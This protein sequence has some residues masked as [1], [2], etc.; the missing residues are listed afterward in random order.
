MARLY[1]SIVHDHDIRLV[2]VA[3]AICLVATVTTFAALE[4]ARRGGRREAAWVALAGFVSAIGIWSTHFVAMLAYSPDIAI[5]YELDATLLSVLAAAFIGGAGWSTF[6][7]NSAGASIAAGALIG[8]AIGT[9]HYV[10][11]AAVNMAGHIHWNWWLVAASLVVGVALSIAAV[12]DYRRRPQF[13]AW[14][15]AAL[16]TSA[17]V[18]LHFTAMAAAGVHSDSTQVAAEAIDNRALA[19]IIAGATLL[20]LVIS[21]VTVFFQRKLVRLQ[22]EEALRAKVMEDAVR[23]GDLQRE[24][25]SCELKEQADISSAAL[26]SMA[27]GLSIY[28]EQDRLVIFNRRY[29][30]L[31]RMPQTLLARGT[32]FADVLAFHIANGSLHRD[33]LEQY[34]ADARGSQRFPGD[35]RI[36]LCDGRIIDVQR[37]PLPHGGWVATHEDVTRQRRAAERSEYLATHD[38]LTG[39]PNRISFAERLDLALAGLG[40]GSIHALLLVDL[41]RFKEVND[42]FGHPVGDELLKQVAVRLREVAGEDVV[43]RLAGD[44]FAVIQRDVLRAHDA[45]ELAGR[46]I[47]TLSRPFDMDGRTITIG[48]S[49]GIA[50]APRDS[51][52][53]ADLLRKGD[54]ALYWVKNV[55]RGGFSF[56]TPRMDKR[57]KERREL[58]NDLRIA[59]QKGQ[60]ELY[61]QPLLNLS[62]RRISGFEALVRWHHPRRGMLQSND[63]IPV[64]EESGLIVEIGEWV[65]RQACVEAAKWPKPV[66][67]SVN[68]SAVQFKRG[69]LLA[70]TESALEAAGLEPGRL[71]L[72]ITE[73]VLLDDE[74]WIRDILG[75]LR[76]LGVRIAMDDFGTG[77]SGL[78]YLRSFPFSKIKIDRS[79]VSDITVTRDALAIVQ[80]TIQLSEKLGIST[81]AEGIETADQLAMLA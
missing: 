74:S 73:S 16:F 52:D 5:R 47:A 61:Y 26:D 28:D 33:N 76:G 53:A 34:L 27:Q 81:T 22:V 43:S 59:V 64:A 56:Y 63:F 58:G 32:A 40:G 68:L 45:G 2:V 14:R 24:Q 4:H 72:E 60:F 25:L 20:M 80:A 65:L 12:V 57:L 9:M 21:L 41:D 49:I 7:R 75:K 15:P 35:S 54:L 55:G 3:L 8:I 6:L 48:A 18:G 77:Y 30:D 37:R 38:H 13:L 50:L 70:M 31:Y 44:E 10:G 78:S 23:A 39:L 67:V 29:A 17:I 19:A 51:R 42:S 46:I 69:N 79:F 36:E 1:S 71:E 66:S 62:S 11:M